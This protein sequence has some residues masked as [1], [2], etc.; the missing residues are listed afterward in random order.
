MA[1]RGR[2]KSQ[3]APLARSIAEARP[4]GWV[5]ALGPARIA[6]W[7]WDAANPGRRLTVTIEAEGRILATALADNYRPDL[8]A[9]GK[10]DGRHG[11][12]AAIA[13]SEQLQAGSAKCLVTALAY[14]IPRGRGA[15][16]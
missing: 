7:V 5:D 16:G 4:E 9:A 1:K 15:G 14:E 3:P 11:F 12:S 13:A 2:R 10:G 6:G 8:E